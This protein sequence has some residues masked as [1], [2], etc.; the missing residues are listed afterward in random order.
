MIVGYIQMVVAVNCAASLLHILFLM[1]GA[2][3][4]LKRKCLQKEAIER[5]IVVARKEGAITGG[6]EDA[7]HEKLRDENRQK[8][9]SVVLR[10]K[11]PL[12]KKPKVVNF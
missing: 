1:K 6:D 7:Y 11:P 9:D 5:A 3:D 8:Q 12:K 4:H 2:T 10:A